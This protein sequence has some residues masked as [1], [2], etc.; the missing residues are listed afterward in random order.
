MWFPA[1]K[2]AE[3]LS[4]LAYHA[5][6]QRDARGFFNLIQTPGKFDA[7]LP[8]R[9][10]H[11]E[12]LV[13]HALHDLGVTEPD[14]ALVQERTW[15]MLARL[16]VLMPRLESPDDADWAGVVNNLRPVVLDSDLGN[17]PRLRD[18]LVGLASEYSP[19]AAQVDLTI[20]RRDAHALLDPTARRHHRGWQILNSIDRQA[21]EAVR[22]EITS[23]DGVRSIFLDRNAAAGELVKVV[24]DA[25]AVVVSGESGVGKSALAVSGLTAAPD[26][27]LQGLQVLRI[28]LRH[29]PELAMDLEAR[30]GHP[31]STLLCELSA[32]QRILV[33]DGADA[34][35]AGRRE[36]FRYL[37]GAAR[38]SGV[39][40][41]AVTS[42]DSKQVVL[43]DLKERFGKGVEEFP[44]PLLEDAELDE[45]VG[46]FPELERLYANPRSQELLRRLVVVDLLVRGQI[47][48]TPLTGADAMNEVWSGLVRRHE[49]SDAGFPDAREMALLRLAEL[50]FGEGERLDVISGI[51][52]AALD[53][54]R[55]DGLL[56]TSND[57]PFMIGPEFAHDEVRRYAVARLLLAGDNPGSRLL[58]AG[59]P[60]WSLAGARI[61]CQAWLERPDTS[62]A[63]LKGRFIAL[64]GSF[65]ALVA[66]GHGSRWSDVPSEALISLGDSAALLR[67][68]WPKLLAD[69]ASGLRR[70]ARLVDQRLR[71]GNGVV[72]VISVEPIV[73]LLLEQPSP[74]QSGEYV[75]GLLRAWLRGHAFARTAAGHPLRILLRRRFVEACA[76]GDRR[77]AEERKAA[78]A[79]RAARTPEEVERDR[80]NAERDSFIF[81]TI[82]YGGRSTRRRPEVPREMKDEVVLELLALL[83]PDLG[84][85]GEKILT[86]VAKDA[87]SWLHPAVDDF[88]AG[89]ALASGRRGL[90]AKLTEAYY[91]DDEVNVAESGVFE[92]GIRGHHPKSLNDPPA[93]WHLGL[94]MSLFQTDFRNGVAMFNRL[95][96]HAARGRVSTL[97]RLYCGDGPIEADSFGPYE[98]ELRISGTPQRYVGD[99]HVWRWYRGTGVGPYPCL[100]AFQALER[101]CDQLIEDGTPLD[102]LVPILLD[103]CENL[104]MAGFVVGLLVRHLEQTGQLLDPYLTEPVIWRQEFARVANEASPFAF[105]SKD[106]VAPGRRRWS[107]REA[108]MFMAVQANGERAAQ[109]RALGEALIAHARHLIAA[110]RGDE[111]TD[112][113]C[114]RKFD[115]RLLAP[116]RAWASSLDRDCCHVYEAEDGLYL[117]ATPPE[118]V[119]VALQESRRDLELGTEATRLLVRYVID[120]TKEYAPPIGADE[121]VADI[122]VVRNLLENPRSLGGLDPWDTAALVAAAA[123]KAHLVDGFDLPGDV[124]SFAAEIVLQ[125]GDFDAQTRPTSSKARSMKRGPAGAQRGLFRCCSF[126][127]MR[128][129]LA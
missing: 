41:I 75:V 72:D 121:L 60:R 78:A 103:G 68:A 7:A 34:V 101:T 9:L 6:N 55:R 74:W 13:Q 33:V 46:V 112:V 79:A 1:Q 87:P 120:P 25:Q 123:L 118:D 91:L 42:F 99:E 90:L 56:R 96:N 129:S 47:S 64:Q 31:L 50:E 111:S 88:F 32:P 92:D 37:V 114:D 45:I 10:G 69:D 24:S 73:T 35:A 11:L 70:L 85:D 122:A 76:A 128:I 94:F 23:G 77:L 3:Q 20:L 119:L 38:D 30:L 104:A 63:P 19:T 61:A 62:K 115:D 18:R 49:M 39:K 83:G 66:K 52:P 44:V 100:S 124:V 108:A 67:D 93:A 84:E 51:D 2:H 26:A 109:L 106:V 110:T 86:R 48:G 28:N 89:Q 16:T 15:Q 125:V 97:A 126:L 107:L 80:Q 22:A 113:S 40:L 27:D 105:D 8:K 12:S 98:N 65:D 117:Q 53:G 57:A 5:A 14:S 58:R 29:I 71:D 21:R 102:D 59:A 82:G 95:R 36:A 127:V 4:T 81:S 54:L 116:V 43:D 17:A